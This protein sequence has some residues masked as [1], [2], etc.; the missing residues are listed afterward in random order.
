[1]KHIFITEIDTLIQLRLDYISVETTL[2]QEE[3]LR[4]AVHLRKYFIEHVASGDFVAYAVEEDGEI[5]SVAF[6]VVG[7][8]PP[9]LSFLNG[10][11]GTIMNVMTYPKFRGKGYA[12]AVMTELINDAKMKC[13]PILDLYA[14]EMG[15]RLYRKLGFEVVPYTAMSLKTNK[16]QM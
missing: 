15:N 1:M 16:T 10:R 6:L 8:R 11:I 4:L 7:V 2:T 13:V 5:A 3:E 14:T 9:G 12:T